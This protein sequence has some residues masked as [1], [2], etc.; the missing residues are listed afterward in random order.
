MAALT[1][2]ESRGA[3]SRDDFTKRDDQKW[4]KHLLIYNNGEI[5][6]RAVNMHPETLEPFAPAERT[7]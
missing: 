4:L 5:K 1:R 6:F 7:Y 2:E 3:H